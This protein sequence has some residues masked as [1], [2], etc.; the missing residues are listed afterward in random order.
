MLPS[1]EP[2]MIKTMTASV[3]PQK[4]KKPEKNDRRP[5]RESLRVDEQMHEWLT[6]AGLTSFSE[7]VGRLFEFR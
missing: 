3:R 5:G 6:L 2:H 4:I 7:L 1:R